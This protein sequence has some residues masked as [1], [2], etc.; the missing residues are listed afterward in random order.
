MSLLGPPLLLRIH[1]LERLTGVVSRLVPPTGA[2]WL[3][4]TEYHS[5]NMTTAAQCVVCT[6]SLSACRQCI[7]SMLFRQNLSKKFP[8]ISRWYQHYKSSINQFHF[9][10]HFDALKRWNYCVIPKCSLC[11]PMSRGLALITSL[12]NAQQFLALCSICICWHK[13][14]G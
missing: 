4:P 8:R 2:D 14:V 10:L 9:I 5:W 11:T 7:N 1:T 12:C 13:I 6:V 3:C